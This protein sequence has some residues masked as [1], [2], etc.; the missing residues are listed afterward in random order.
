MTKIKGNKTTE[1]EA[2]RGSG[3]KKFVLDDYIS[4]EGNEINLSL[5]WDVLFDPE[6][7]KKLREEKRD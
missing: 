5:P 6:K 4:F 2:N 3:R 7:N 1:D